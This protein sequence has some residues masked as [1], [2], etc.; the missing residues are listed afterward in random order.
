NCSGLNELIKEANA[1]RSLCDFQILRI[2]VWHEWQFAPDGIRGKQPKWVNRVG[3]Q[4][5][6][7]TQV[8][9]IKN[10]ALAGAHTRTDVDVWSIE[11]AVESGRRAA[12]VFEPSVRVLGQYRPSW[13]LVLRA[14]DNALYRLNAP[15]VLDV[16]LIVLS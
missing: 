6:L 2:E 13:L 15:N 7:P 9:P 8:T 11:A 16:M 12:Q 3:N 5:F 1:G 10:L 4:A 14:L